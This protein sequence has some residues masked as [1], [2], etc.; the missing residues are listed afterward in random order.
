MKEITMKNLHVPMA[1]VIAMALTPL[2]AQTT[3]PAATAP[4]ASAAKVRDC[5]KPRHD[6]GAEKGTPTPMSV[7]CAAEDARGKKVKRAHDHQKV[8]NK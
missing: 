7:R 1:L 3:T 4:A 5:E 2:F 8:H 6:H